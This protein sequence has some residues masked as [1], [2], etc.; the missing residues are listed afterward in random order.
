MFFLSEKERTGVYSV[1]TIQ[2]ALYDTGIWQ[3]RET[4][5][6]HFYLYGTG[7]DHWTRMKMMNKKK[8]NEQTRNIQVQ[9]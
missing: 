6:G 1:E 5:V 4:R 2:N 7:V 3:C 9:L 8:H